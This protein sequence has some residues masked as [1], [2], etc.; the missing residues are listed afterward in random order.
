MNFSVVKR[1]NKH[2]V[3]VVQLP[4]LSI[5][6]PWAELV[7]RGL[8]QWDTRNWGRKIPTDLAGHWLAIHASSTTTQYTPEE[9]AE[10]GLQSY[11]VHYGV[12]LGI[13]KV[14][15]VHVVHRGEWPDSLYNGQ[16]IPGRVGIRFT[17][18]RRLSV[19][20]PFRGRPKF[21]YV[22]IPN[23]FRL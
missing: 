4:A 14:A 11:E 1:L 5:H 22:K 6:Q 9:I 15:E 21:F 18:P 20:L 23:E 8:R 2:N 19:P 17:E 7:M 13:A 12:V 3:E 10:V 16:C